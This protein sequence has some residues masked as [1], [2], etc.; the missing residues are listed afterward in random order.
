M[1]RLNDKFKDNATRLTS[2]EKKTGRESS[3][4]VFGGDMKVEINEPG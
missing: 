2:R 4:P 3:L 1:E